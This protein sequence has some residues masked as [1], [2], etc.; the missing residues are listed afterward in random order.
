MLIDIIFAVIIVL[1]VIRGFQKGL[2]VAVFSF[3]AFF[4]GLAAALKLSA[5]AAG[6]IGK[7]VKVS[8]RWLPVISFALV[9]IVVII[10]VHLGAKMIEKSFQVVM[11]GWLNRAGGILFYIIIY[12]TIF[13]VLLFYARQV[14]LIQPETIKNSVTYEYV[15]P[16]APKAINAFGRVI[17]VFKD[18][19]VQLEEF[20]GNLSGKI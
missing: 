10:L 3:V 2:I 12:I 4:I 17:P 1:A 9:F 20:F 7:T 8:D 15:Q 13:S 19:F 16:W 18:M 14:N 6:Y 11:L 5:V